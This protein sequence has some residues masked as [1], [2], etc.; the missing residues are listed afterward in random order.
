MT[1]KADDAALGYVVYALLDNQ[2]GHYTG[3]FNSNRYSIDSSAAFDLTSKNDFSVLRFDTEY[4][5]GKTTAVR[6]GKDT[7]TA[8][9]MLTQTQFDQFMRQGKEK[10]ALLLMIVACFAFLCCVLMSKKYVSP[11]L[12]KIEQ[13]KTNQDYSNPIRISEIDDLFAF[14]EERD[15]YYERQLKTLENAKQLA[16]EEANQSKL[17]Y[18]NAIKKYELALS[19]ITQLG[20][21]HQK[22][23]V[24][25]D[26]EF[27]ICNLNT[28]TPTEYRIY[29][30]YPAGK[31]AKQI[32]EMLGITE[33]TLKYHNKNIYSKLGISSRKQLLRFASLKQHQDSKNGTA[34]S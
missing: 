8:A 32:T 2:Q 17:A 18:E 16:E 14:L 9:I 12:K 10:F 20:E 15:I 24:L 25:E 6:L 3:Q 23:I 1:H 19:E 13:I 7:F 34:P 33:N 21:Q 31:N 30:L 27:F 28:L 22:N 26:Y 11:I 5:I 4:C 29:E